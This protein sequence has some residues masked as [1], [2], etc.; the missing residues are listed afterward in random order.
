MVDPATHHVKRAYWDC[1]EW[2][3]QVFP[4]WRLVVLYHEQI[5]TLRRDVPRDAPP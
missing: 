4:P 1:S 3:A 2:L 5:S